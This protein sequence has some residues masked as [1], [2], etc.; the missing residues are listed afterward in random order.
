[1]SVQWLSS[2]L[3]YHGYHKTKTCSRVELVIIE[4]ARVTLLLVCSNSIISHLHLPLWSHGLIHIYT[5]SPLTVIRL[6]L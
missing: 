5:D 2:L 1:M 6:G 4:S 3:L